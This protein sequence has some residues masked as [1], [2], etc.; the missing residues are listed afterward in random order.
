MRAVFLLGGFVGFVVVAISG[1]QAGRSGDRVLIDAS[2]ACIGSALLFR[3]FWSR[4]VNAL[5]DTVKKKRAVRQAAEEAAAA[6]KATPVAAVK[7]K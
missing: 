7:T 6:A 3:W 4:L 1:F 2:L 5:A